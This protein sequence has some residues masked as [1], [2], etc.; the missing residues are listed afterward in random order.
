MKKSISGLFAIVFIMLTTLNASAQNASEQTRDVSG[1][2]KVAIGGPFK[3]RIIIGDKEGVTLNIDA[4]Y[5]DKVETKVE[6]NTLKVQFQKSSFSHNIHT[7]NV[8]VYAKSLS[9]LANAGSG[10]VTV[11]GSISSDDFKMV[12]SGSGSVNIPVLKASGE[13][14]TTLSGSGSISVSGSSSS[15][16]AVLSGSRSTG[17]SLVPT[18]PA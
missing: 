8:T 3:T 17:R 15:V 6:N 2:N 13:L 4:E 12:L 11:E 18:K 16:N 10:S 1:Y 5:I 14:S 9:A 7:A